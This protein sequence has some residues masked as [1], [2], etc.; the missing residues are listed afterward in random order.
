MNNADLEKAI[1][2]SGFPCSWEFDSCFK[3]QVLDGSFRS[4][5]T[6]G[7]ILP[8]VMRN[9]WTCADG[10]SRSGLII[11]CK[12]AR[13]TEW[14]FLREKSGGEHNSR[15]AVRVFVTAVREG[16]PPQYMN[17]ARFL[18]F[19]ALQSVRLYRSRTVSVARSFGTDRGGRCS[20][21]GGYRAPRIA[22][23]PIKQEA[24]LAEFTL[25]LL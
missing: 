14:I 19:R 4:G 18:T 21:N 12:R 16:K 23:L 7:V 15:L 3:A 9:L 20:S 25:R 10:Q 5:N 22:T 11:E 2:D 24:G 13:D 1:N 17:G 8:L 6:R